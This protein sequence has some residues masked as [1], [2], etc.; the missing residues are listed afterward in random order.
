MSRSAKSKSSRQWLNEH[1]SD[2]YVKRAQREG[3]RARSV[4]KLTEIQ[5]KQAII[6]RGMTVIDLGAAPGSWSEYVVKLVGVSG[7]VIA[8][9]ILP[10]NPIPRVIFTQGDVTDPTVCTKL[11]DLIGQ[12]KADV[13]ISDMAPNLSGLRDVDD[14]RVENLMEMAF[15]FAG[16][17][18]KPGGVLLIKT[19]Q[20]GNF[21]NTLDL[22]RSKFSEVK[23]VKPDASRARSREI[24]LLAKGFKNNN[25][26][27]C[28]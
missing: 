10:M 7:R 3:H 1:F 16:K 22:L 20:A 12:A 11:L 15:V 24:F 4:Y 23:V 8:A 18:L 25:I 14:A 21:K 2:S 19:F 9:D 5:Q 17:V 28:K 27:V 13:V 6:K 26:G